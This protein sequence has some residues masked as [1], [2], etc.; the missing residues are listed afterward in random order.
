MFSVFETHRAYLLRQFLD[1]FFQHPVH[2]RDFVLNTDGLKRI[3]RLTA[4][5]CL[6]YDFANNVASDSMVQVL[7]TMAEVATNETL[8]QLIEF[9]KDSLSD[10]QFLW[11]SEQENSKLLALVDL[12]GEE[13][14]SICFFFGFLRLVSRSGKCSC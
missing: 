3:G 12:S 2:C 5:P 11:G 9:V 7:R 6:P 1:G 8:S 4:L 10:T 14:D 13:K